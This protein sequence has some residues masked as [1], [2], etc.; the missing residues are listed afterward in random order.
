VV[1]R[2]DRSGGEQHFLEDTPAE[3]FDAIGGLAEPVRLIQRAIQLHFDHPEIAAKYQLRPTRA[4]L[5]VGPPGGGK[6]LIAK[7]T[8]NWVASR[9]ASGRSRFINVKPG[10]LHSM[11]YGQSEAN[12]REAF[13]AARAASEQDPGG[14]SSRAMPRRTPRDAGG[15]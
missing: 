11:W 15:V 6:T 5:L 10:G 3:T 14:A 2:L 4:V 9:S 8:A 1:E 13:R 12:Y 7:A